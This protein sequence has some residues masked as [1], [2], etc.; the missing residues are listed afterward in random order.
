V[1]WGV[2]S[3]PTVSEGVQ[4]VTRS[5][6]I[7]QQSLG[8][9]MSLLFAPFDTK[10]WLVLV[11]I[12]FFHGWLTWYVDNSHHTLRTRKSHLTVMQKRKAS[13]APILLPSTSKLRKAS[14]RKQNQPQRI[15]SGDAIQEEGFQIFPDLGEADADNYVDDTEDDAQVAYAPMTSK[16]SIYHACISCAGEHHIDPDSTE[17]REL[18]IG[19]IFF[20]F[21]IITIYSANLT[22]ILT[23][24]PETIDVYP[25][26]DTGENN[27]I[28]YVGARF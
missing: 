8:E 10:V 15:I 3:N 7:K 20:V 5:A 11:A 19:W 13:K 23:L 4:F 26:L 17:L 9:R 14:S 25:G 28:M 27:C 6:V 1:S 24:G 22:A 21:I 2:W 16:E 12:V 18:S